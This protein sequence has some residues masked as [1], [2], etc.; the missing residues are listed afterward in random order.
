MLHFKYLR[1]SKIKIVEG[2]KA[3]KCFDWNCAF[4]R[5]CKCDIKNQQMCVGILQKLDRNNNWI[6]HL[7]YDLWQNSYSA[8]VIF[9]WETEV[10]KYIH[11][12]QITHIR[13]F[14]NGVS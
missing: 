4:S 11:N 9:V 10:C 1:Y 6:K 2:K 12:Y 14:L 7:C 5:F 13:K 8:C 3:L